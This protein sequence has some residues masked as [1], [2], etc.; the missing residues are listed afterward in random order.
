[1]KMNIGKKIKKLAVVGAVSSIGLVGATSALATD[2]LDLLGSPSSTPKTTETV[3]ST[4]NVFDHNRLS[5]WNGFT[6]KVDCGEEKVCKSEKYNGSTDS[7]IFTLDDSG[8]FE[9]ET[10]DCKDGCINET[11][12]HRARLM[13]GLESDS[14]VCN[15]FWTVRSVSGDLFKGIPQ[16]VCSKDYW[17]KIQNTQGDEVYTYTKYVVPVSNYEEAIQ[18]CPTGTED[19]VIFNSKTG[20]VDG[21]V[22]LTPGV[23]LQGLYNNVLNAESKYPEMLNN[24]GNWVANVGDEQISVYDSNGQWSQQFVDTVQSLNGDGNR[25]IYMVHNVDLQNNYDKNDIFSLVLPNGSTLDGIP[26]ANLESIINSQNFTPEQKAALIAYGPKEFS[27][28]YQNGVFTFSGHKNGI[29][30]EKYHIKGNNNQVEDLDGTGVD[31]AFTLFEVVGPQDL[32]GSYQFPINQEDE[33]FDKV[34]FQKD[35]N[36]GYTGSVS[37][38]YNNDSSM[39]EVVSN[40][41]FRNMMLKGFGMTSFLN[42][43]VSVNGQKENQNYRGLLSCIDNATGLDGAKEVMGYFAESQVINPID[44]EDLSILVDNVALND[45]FATNAQAHID[46]DGKVAFNEND[47]AV[48][49]GKYREFANKDSTLGKVIRYTHPVGWLEFAWNGFSHDVTNNRTGHVVLNY[50]PNKLSL[51]D[52][53]SGDGLSVEVMQ[54]RLKQNLLVY[55]SNLG[56][57]N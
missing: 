9:I 12:A 21:A 6:G 24:K 42:N 41:D 13:Q 15:D 26:A 23:A 3:K 1:M 46:E 11:L 56:G 33:I 37:I 48:L 32:V 50:N 7:H 43:A 57:N 54:D 14:E 39:Q 49:E 52:A 8:V 30:N 22:Y 28:V 36:G 18:E 16:D 55:R 25:D 53:L 47:M 40:E 44:V 38:Q 19:L 4:Q 31:G 17:K 29:D 34:T 5:H 45:Y 2:G 27:L 10:R 35:E 51:G 20:S